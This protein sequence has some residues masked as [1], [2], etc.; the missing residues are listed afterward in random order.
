MKKF[1]YI[2]LLLSV[3]CGGG[4]DSVEVSKKPFKN[5]NVIQ[6][7]DKQVLPVKQNKEQV[8]DS[9]TQE[10]FDELANQKLNRFFDMINLSKQTKTSKDFINFTLQNA[11]K[12][13]LKPENAKSFLQQPAIQ[14]ADSLELNTLSFKNFETQETDE[15]LA[16]YRLNYIIYYKGQGRNI[17]T[18]AQIYFKILHLNFDG[19]KYLSLKAKIFRIQ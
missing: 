1:I 10:N 6:R 4:K 14:S 13:W 11:Q 9:I 12:L 8:Q 2:L 17:R 18:K 3:A 7:F 16:T 19:Q 5:K 15:I